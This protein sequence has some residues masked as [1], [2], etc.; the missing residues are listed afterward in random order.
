MAHLEASKQP[1]CYFFV[2]EKKPAMSLIPDLS[3][4]AA[5][6]LIQYYTD[7][8]HTDQF[9]SRLKRVEQEIAQT[10]TYTHTYEELQYGAR[11]AW[12][13]S[14]RCIGRLYWKSLKV[15][16]ARHL[17]SPEEAVKALEHHLNFATN[18]GDI[19]STITIFKPATTTD[20]A[21]KIVNPQ[22]IRYAGYRQSDGTV[23]GD[24]TH[25][26]LTQRCIA[27]GW[28]PEKTPFDVLPWIIEWPGYA[29]C[30]HPVPMHLVLEV[31]L[32]HPWI[33][34]L[35][36]LGLRWHA[37][38]AVSDMVLEI[39][40]IRYTAAPF[41]GWYMG[42]EIGSRNL[43][44][45]HRYNLLPLIAQTI[46]LDTGA[47]YSLWK[48]RALVELNTAVL[49][50]FEKAGVRITSHHEAS[51]QFVHFENIETK[52]GRTTQADWSW[53][54]P[55]MSASSMEVFHRSYS[56]EERSPNFYHRS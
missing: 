16:D 53:I 22:L 18:A 8:N 1:D 38:P 19:R 33:H 25:I 31:P 51:S 27:M 36:R 26:E 39:G 2:L 29:P 5:D 47:P 41:N 40:G 37:L 13:N 54:V 21:P 32:S 28:Q 45:T 44:D 30:L 14:T 56:N 48:D 9:P 50:S 23:T 12:R 11:L 20:E 52:H 34:E 24:P 17:N 46:G 6:F 15:L 7:L 43:G 10:G 4:Q 55:P 3:R 35:A 49:Y 42:T